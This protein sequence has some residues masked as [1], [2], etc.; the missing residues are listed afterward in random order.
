MEFTD[1]KILKE[2]PPE[3]FQSIAS[4]DTIIEETWRYLPPTPAVAK[5]LL[6][7]QGRQLNR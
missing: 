4:N 6:E 7:R 5:L 2:L 3:T 1:P